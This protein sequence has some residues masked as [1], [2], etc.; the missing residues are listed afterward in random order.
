MA[1]LRVI[2]EHPMLARLARVEPEALL[3]ELNR[4]SSAVFRLVRGFLVAQIRSSQAV[5]ELPDGD[6]AALAEIAVRLGASFVLI[7]DSSIVSDDEQRTRETMRLLLAPV[8]R[9]GR[10]KRRRAA[11][12]DRPKAVPARAV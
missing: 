6:P 4:D 7:P 11:G 2:R 8:L 10:P 3:H 1:T 9:D 5:G 12:G